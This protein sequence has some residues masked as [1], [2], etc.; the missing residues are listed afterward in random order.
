MMKCVIL[1]LIALAIS[2]SSQAKT[3]PMERVFMCHR[4]HESRTQT[5]T[6]SVW[7][8]SLPKAQ[9]RL[10]VVG[11]LED[12]DNDNAPGPDELD[13][14]VLYRRPEVLKPPQITATDEDLSDYV[15]FR[16]MLARMKALQ[17]YNSLRG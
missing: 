9:R 4:Q 8:H 10:A 11:D 2:N 7:L 3:N 14:Q 6:K 16:L 12:D 17:K 1:V 13:L 5:Q 15:R